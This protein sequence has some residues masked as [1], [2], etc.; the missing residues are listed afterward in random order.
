MK[1]ETIELFPRKYK[2]FFSDPERGLGN[3][4][5]LHISIAS[6][7]KKTIKYIDKDAMNNYIAD[8]RD[9]FLEHDR[10]LY[11]FLVKYIWLRSR[12]GY[13][14]GHIRDNDMDRGANFAFVVFLNKY[15]DMERRNYVVHGHFISTLKK[16]LP[17]FF[18]GFY[19]HRNPFTEKLEFPFKNLTLSYLLPVREMDEAIA[20]LQYAD[21]RKFS[22]NEFLDFLANWTACYNDKYG[23]KYRMRVKLSG[24]IPIYVENL[25]KKKKEKYEKL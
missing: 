10:H 25:L 4:K 2:H 5:P 23:E 15:V 13:L 12:F 9:L 3:C 14:D 20:I 19:Y 6:P 11:N 17:Y 7:Y 8:F 21:S 24:N 18:S 22:F 1:N 16:F